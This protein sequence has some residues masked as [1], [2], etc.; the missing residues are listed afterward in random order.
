MRLDGDYVSI[1]I[2]VGSAV[3]VSPLERALSLDGCEFIRIV[4]PRG[5]APAHELD[6]IP[7]VRAAADAAAPVGKKKLASFC[8]AVT[9]AEASRVLAQYEAHVLK[10]RR[11]E[12]RGPGGVSMQ[13]WKPIAALTGGWRDNGLALLAVRGS[14]S[15]LESFVVRSVRSADDSKLSH[16]EDQHWQQLKVADIMDRSKRAASV[17][18]GSA[19]DALKD[20]ADGKAFFITVRV[21]P[22]QLSAAGLRIDID[23]E[24][25]RHA[26]V[27]KDIEGAS[28][29]RPHLFLG[30]DFEKQI[31][32]VL[33]K[34]GYRI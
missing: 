31:D 7:A 1:Q 27:S 29:A 5:T 28:A 34:E 20:W 30:D 32:S 11:D 25:L 15:I 23:D 6:A 18:P 4:V 8:C 16:T 2:E 17:G 21:L 33:R 14:G 24:S 26:S 13:R 22:H 12:S 3:M 10:A 19:G 9:P